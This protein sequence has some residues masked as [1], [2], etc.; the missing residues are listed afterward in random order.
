ML[1]HKG[2][3][4]IIIYLLI[5]ALTHSQVAWITNHHSPRQAGNKTTGTPTAGKAVWR[6]H[7]KQMLI[8]LVVPQDT[9]QQ[10]QPDDTSE[11]ETQG[12]L[13]N[14][15]HKMPGET[16]NISPQGYL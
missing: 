14:G 7:R 13:R 10:I 5:H 8:P 3:S 4:R 6:C 2:L 16:S 11:G 1:T 12:R 15:T 9:L